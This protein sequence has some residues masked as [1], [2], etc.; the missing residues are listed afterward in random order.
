MR[1]HPQDIAEIWQ[2]LVTP[3]GGK[4]VYLILD[5]LGG[6]ADRQRG[7]T[8]LQVANT[9][10]LD[11]LAGESSCGLLEIVG[12]GVTPGSGPGHLALFGYDPLR[13]MIGRGILSALGIDFDLQEGG[14]AAR[15]NFATLDQQ[16][17]VTDRR[18]GRIPTEKNKSLAKRIREEVSL[19]FEGEYF[20]ET[21][22]EHRAVLI[23]R[24]MEL[25]RKVEDTDPQHTGVPPRDPMPRSSSAKKTA[26]LIRRFLDQVADVLKEESPANGILLRGFDQYQAFP[27][28]QERFALQGVCLA[29]YPMYRG[30]SRLLGLAVPPPPGGLRQRVECLRQEVKNSHDF[31]FLHV[32]HTDSR[33]EDGDFD[34]KVKAIEEVDALI[35]LIRASEPDV[36][37]VTADHSTPAVM[38]RHSWHPVPVL[39]HAQTAR[40]DKVN[41]FDEEACLHGALGIR[42]GHHLMGLA[43]AH[44]GRLQKFGA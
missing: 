22:S 38:G 34:A 39:I 36:L 29:D 7:G 10:N 32:K 35:P 9:P 25:S 30:L 20:F 18:A 24:G 6:L 2:R 15:V 27:S 11:D 1:D 40:R 41:R 26:Q 3:D 12:P 4:I 43:L 19:E 17:I 37:V 42:P 31:Y 21:V 28:L 16:G 8:E 14:I 23:L 13:Y 44:A 5:G 33:G